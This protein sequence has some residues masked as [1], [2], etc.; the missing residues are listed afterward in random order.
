MKI[1]RFVAK[2]MRQAMREVREEQ[3]PDAV[4]LSTRRLA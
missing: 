2:D 4:I 3:G 1:K